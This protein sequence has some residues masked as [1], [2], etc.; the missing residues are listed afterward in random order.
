MS[1]PYP[2]PDGLE[3]VE[4]VEL[5]RPLV[6]VTRAGAA[7]LGRWYWE[8]LEGSTRGL[9]RARAAGAG[10]GIVLAGS[11]TLLRFA[12]PEIRV[13]GRDVECRY[14]ILGGCLASRPGGSL[15]IAQRDGSA[16]QLE[17]AVTGY[18]PRL[19]GR[20]SRFHRG[21]LYTALQAPLHRAISRRFLTRTAVRPR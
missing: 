20:G 18:H 4:H 8:E 2:T 11:L 16:P 17:V 1:N 5:S 15:A 6:P 12:E 14:P 9:V 13:E 7:E 19:A 21:L 3:T 10:V